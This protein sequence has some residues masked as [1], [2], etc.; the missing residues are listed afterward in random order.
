MA[1]LNEKKEKQLLKFK[2]QLQLGI[3]Y[4]QELLP[5]ISGNL[6]YLQ[7]VKNDLFRSEEKLNSL[8]IQVPATA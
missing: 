6:Q 2:D 3:R 7:E 1:Q 8:E 4:Y 5:K